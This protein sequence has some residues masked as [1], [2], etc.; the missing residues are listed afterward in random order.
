MRW[1]N[2]QLRMK[3]THIYG[4]MY[5]ITIES[6]V[7]HIQITILNQKNISWT[8]KIKKTAFDIPNYRTL[9][10]WRTLNWRRRRQQAIN[11]NKS[12]SYAL[13]CSAQVGLIF[14]F[15]I[16][17]LFLFYAKFYLWLTRL[18]YSLANECDFFYLFQFAFYF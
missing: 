18:C 4:E 1:Y 6:E 16:F 2:M 15:V 5:V 10:V 13:L 3:R 8:K 9:N 11:N 17:I 14:F 7:P 12:I